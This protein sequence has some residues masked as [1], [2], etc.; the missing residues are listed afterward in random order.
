MGSKAGLS[1]TDNVVQF[2]L[3]IDDSI[4]EENCEACVL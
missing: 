3:Q 4:D 1:E 2:P